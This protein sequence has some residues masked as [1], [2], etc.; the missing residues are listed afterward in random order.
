MTISL[1]K[2]CICGNTS[3]TYIGKKNGIPL[4]KC[5][6]GILH[7][8]LKMTKEAYFDFYANGYHTT[9][10]KKIGCRSYKERYGHDIQISKKR[11]LSY[12]EYIKPNSRILDIGSANSAFINESD[13][14]GHDAYGVELNEHIV[15]GD[16]TYIGDLFDHSFPTGV[17]DVVTLHDVLEHLIN[18]AE[19]IQ[20]IHRILKPGGRVIIDFPQYYSAKGL[21]HWREI[22]HL[23]YLNV[24]QLG[25]MIRSKGFDAENVYSPIPGK[26]VLV[27]KRKEVAKK[28]RILV[29]PGM[30]DIYWVA[31]LLED[32]IKKHKIQDAQVAIWDFDGR[33][34]SAEFV[35]KIPFVSW[36]G[37]CSFPKDV[38][39]LNDSYIYDHYSIKE[40]LF[41]FDYYF[42]VNGH[43]REG[44]SLD[45]I[46]GYRTNWDL[47]LFESLEE[48]RFGVEFKKEHGLY[49]VC[50][51]TEHGM[52]EQWVKDM[53][54]YVIGDM[55]NDIHTKFGYK[56][57][58]TGC[59]WDED[60]VNR[61]TPFMAEGSFIDLA[62][63]TSIDQ[64]FGLMKSSAGV[65][66]WCGGN[67]IMSTAFNVPT[68]MF[69]NE[70]FKNSSFF[71]HSCK[72][73]SYK[74]WYHPV[75]TS[76]FSKRAI[77]SIIKKCFRGK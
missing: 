71:K 10:Q 63:K 61:I 42:C 11:L 47:K 43:L 32:F 38:Q 64:L 54:A 55:L 2:Q 26:L 28:T 12:K 20:E 9:H 18:P 23:W 66:G 50:Y 49:V 1:V 70:Y 74:K 6:C 27:A 30:G 58:F 5:T 52:F 8:R 7:Q 67:T 76:K 46:D 14:Q 33:P 53:P 22:Q 68:I 41:G 21:H 35:K 45:K 60:Y 37:Y 75:M 65:I 19:I 56:I 31:V 69:W 40:G 13:R 3:F 29:I 44:K 51:F 17:F 77:N 25:E 34:R 48:K 24:Q 73:K 16:R 4:N 39:V 62:G 72:P 59:K 57:V 15:N 36:G